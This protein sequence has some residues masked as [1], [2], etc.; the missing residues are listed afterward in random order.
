MARSLA[1]FINSIMLFL[2]FSPFPVIETERL[3]LRQMKE[4][5]EADLF[6]IRSNAQVNQYIER[7][8]PESVDVMRTFIEKKNKDIKDNQLLY[9]I[10]ERKIDGKSLGTICLWNIES[11][12]DKVEIGYDMLPDYEGNGFMNEALI[13][14]VRY[15]EDVMKT[16]RIEAYTHRDNIR[17]IRLLERNHFIKELL[18]DAYL[19]KEVS[20]NMAVK[21]FELWVL[22]KG[23]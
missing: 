18:E 3:L 8:A 14:V 21:G 17:S 15:A 6:A 5:D 20:E 16:R 7:K 9:W 23:A 1:I 2:S 13:A 4:G 11:E 22:V 19:S 12:T 10:I